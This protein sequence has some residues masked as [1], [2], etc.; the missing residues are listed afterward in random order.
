[1]DCLK[2]P[3]SFGGQKDGTWKSQPQTSMILAGI[4]VTPDG[5]SIANDQLEILWSTLND[6]KVKTKEDA[7]HVIGVVQYCHT[8]FRMDSDTWKAYSK[9]LY[10]LMDAAN[11]APSQK[12]KVVWG[13]SCID[14][15]TYLTSLITNAPRAMWNPATILDENHCLATMSDASD[16]AYSCRLFNTCTS[17]LTFCTSI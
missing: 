5:F 4:H 17:H 12:A 6:Y 9:A 11:A 3:H 16:D 2:K 1:M 7:Q 13:P 10:T 15:C 14:A 8:A